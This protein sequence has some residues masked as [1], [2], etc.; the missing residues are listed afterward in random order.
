MDRFL[1]QASANA[2]KHRKE[3]GYPLTLQHT[4]DSN[5][6]MYTA[7]TTPVAFTPAIHHP[8]N[9]SIHPTLA[10][11]CT[12]MNIQNAKGRSARGRWV[13]TAAGVGR[14][15]ENLDQM[16]EGRE[17]TAPEVADV[18]S[19]DDVDCGEIERPV[20]R[21]ERDGVLGEVVV[22]GTRDG[23]GTM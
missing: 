8:A 13:D 17:G 1:G 23:E 5:P 15:A 18:A 16:M 10:S 3:D 11:A 19:R 2:K 4:T 14:M 7:P 21:R 12:R 20:R 22:A 6:I 9:T